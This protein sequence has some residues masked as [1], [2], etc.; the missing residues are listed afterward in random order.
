MDDIKLAIDAKDGR[1]YQATIYEG[2]YVPLGFVKYVIEVYL[3]EVDY[4]YPVE[5][6]HSGWLLDDALTHCHEQLEWW[7]ENGREIL[8]LRHIV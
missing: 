3:H 8:L 1:K 6:S 4:W 5:Q 7:A 2:K